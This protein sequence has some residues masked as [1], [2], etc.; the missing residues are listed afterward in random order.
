AWIAER[1]ARF[2]FWSLPVCEGFKAGALNFALSK[3]DPRAEV[4]GVID[5]DYRVEP[6]WLRELMGH[7]VDPQVAVVQAPQAHRDFE[8]DL[9]ARS[10]NWEFEGF[11]RA[12]MHHRNERNAI[13][14]HG[15]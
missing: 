5:A 9:L 14:Q 8:G 10:A 6:E 7:F 4:L 2:R 3:T 11:F 15:T 12:G 13:I 1:P